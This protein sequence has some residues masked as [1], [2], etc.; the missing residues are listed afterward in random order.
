MDKAT[1]T[2]IVIQPLSAQGHPSIHIHCCAVG[3]VT[4]KEPQEKKKT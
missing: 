2:T 4:R 1:P 3:K